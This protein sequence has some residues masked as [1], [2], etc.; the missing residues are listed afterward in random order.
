MK[1]QGNKAT[2]PLST[3][4][5]EASIKLP[6]T[7][8]QSET[9]LSVAGTRNRRLSQP[10]AQIRTKLEP[11]RPDSSRRRQSL[12]VNTKCLTPPIPEKRQPFALPQLQPISTSEQKSSPM[13]GSDVLP[14][15]P[16]AGEKQGGHVTGSDALSH[17]PCDERQNSHVTGN[18]A[19]PQLQTQN[20]N[21]NGHV[22]ESA[23]AQLANGEKQMQNTNGQVI[24]NTLPQLPTSE[25]TSHVAERSVSPQP[26]DHVTG[27]DALPQLPNS[28]TS[29]RQKA[30]SAL[31]Q[32]ATRIG[33]A[34][35]VTGSAA[36]LP[37]LP[38]HVTAVLP[39]LPGH[40]TGSAAVLP[41][42]PGHVT[43]RNSQQRSRVTGSD[44]RK[45]FTRV[46]AKGKQ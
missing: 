5:S 31:P 41:Q 30:N 28:S 40:V 35:H 38:G 37:Q 23:L 2:T 25:Q 9:K 46:R 39:Q 20:S 7:T 19:L 36:A 17:L 42:L 32:L 11:P 44:V 10:V 43:G 3:R 34:G 45:R 15:I 33:Q 27:N 29:K 16:N 1:S 13:K 8:A 6:L 21:C 12:P 14:Q 4:P 24:E 18:S 26:A 22:T